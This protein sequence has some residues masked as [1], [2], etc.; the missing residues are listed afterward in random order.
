M[1]IVIKIAAGLLLLIGVPITIL[2]S[3]DVLNPQTSD[4]DRG[5]SFAALMI[6][7]LPPT[8]LGGLFVYSLR[9]QR[10]AFKERDDLALEQ[11]F[12]KLLQENQGAVSPIVFATQA[13]LSLDEAKKFLDEKAVQLNGLYEAT[14]MGGIIYRFPL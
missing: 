14:E 8:V 6:L 13:Q 2:A 4:E 11:M 5:D 9:Q 3:V 10:Q 1:R 7:G 12:L